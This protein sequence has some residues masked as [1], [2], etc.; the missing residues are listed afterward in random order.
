MSNESKCKPA[1]FL[2]ESA[3]LKFNDVIISCSKTVT[4]I[5][6]CDHTDMLEKIS[7]EV[8]DKSSFVS[9]RARGAYIASTCRPELTFGSSVC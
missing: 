2:F 3:F 4:K 7:V 5:R 6:Q 8:S 1:K 9:K